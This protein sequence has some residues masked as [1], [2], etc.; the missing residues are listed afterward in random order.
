MQYFTFQ[1]LYLV[2]IRSMLQTLGNNKTIYMNKLTLMY[3]NITTLSVTIYKR[4]FGPTSLV[5]ANTATTNHLLHFDVLSHEKHGPWMPHLSRERQSI[6]AD[7]VIFLFQMIFCQDYKKFAYHVYTTT[8]QLHETLGSN[9]NKR[10]D[11]RKRASG[12]H[13][14]IVWFV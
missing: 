12:A 2:Q 6:H 3:S 8:Y 5:W 9:Q 13:L 7:Q 4:I 11:P 14:F 1:V 10:T